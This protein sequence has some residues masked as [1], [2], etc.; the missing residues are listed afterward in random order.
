MDKKYVNSN[1][2]KEVCKVILNKLAYLYSDRP[3]NRWGYLHLQTILTKL[4]VRLHVFAMRKTTDNR[5][6]VA[7]SLMSN[8]LS[9][10]RDKLLLE[11]V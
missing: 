4:G 6:F 1:V 10:I 3:Q 2:E 11:S 7:R 9:K 8:L 5:S